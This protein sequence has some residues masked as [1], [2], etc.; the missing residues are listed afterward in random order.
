MVDRWVESHG[1]A[2]QEIAEQYQHWITPAVAVLLT[3]FLLYFL[4]LFSANLLGPIIVNCET[5]KGRQVISLN[6]D[7]TTR[8][9]ILDE[10]KRMAV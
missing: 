2:F 7:Y 10:L 9:R 5:N 6:P 1:K 4:G 8:H 3:L